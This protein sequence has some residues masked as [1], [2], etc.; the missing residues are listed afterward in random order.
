[1]KLDEGGVTRHGSLD[2]EVI[3]GLEPT[4][5]IVQGAACMQRFRMGPSP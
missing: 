1:V 2:V 3:A 5:M 4:V